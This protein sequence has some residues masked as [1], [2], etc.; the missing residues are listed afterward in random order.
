MPKQRRNVNS[1]LGD[2]VDIL[3]GQV[4]KLE[5]ASQEKEEFIKE[6]KAVNIA[7]AVSLAREEGRVSTLVAKNVERLVQLEYWKGKVFFWRDKYLASKTKACELEDTIRKAVIHALRYHMDHPM[8][9]KLLEEPLKPE[10][11]TP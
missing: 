2:L 7:L 6:L 10:V 3:E 8:L 9:I 1:K 4:K 11:K 5:A